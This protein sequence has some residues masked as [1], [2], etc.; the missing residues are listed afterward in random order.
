MIKQNTGDKNV[1]AGDFIT[2]MPNKYILD[3]LLLN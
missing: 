1:H 3:S 2:L